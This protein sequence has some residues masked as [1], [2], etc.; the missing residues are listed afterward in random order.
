MPTASAVVADLASVAMGAAQI[1][2]DQLN[3]WPDRCPPAEQLSIDA[4]SSRYYV[5]ILA[6]DKPGVL[7]RIDAAMSST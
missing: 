6:E 3:I 4:V 7:A 5:R 1:L 2:F